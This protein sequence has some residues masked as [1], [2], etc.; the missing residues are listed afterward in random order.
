MRRSI[1]LFYQDVVSPFVREFEETRSVLKRAF[2]AV[3][4]L[5]SFASHIFYFHK[6]LQ[7]LQYTGD[8][9]F[10][11]N[12]LIPRSSDFK[13]ILDVSAAA[14][15]ALR[16]NLDKSKTSV[17][18]STDLISMNVEGWAAFFGGLNADEWGDQVIVHNDQHLFA[19]LLPV[20]LRAETF[21]LGIE[22]G[23]AGS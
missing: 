6:D 2:G 14:K 13:L 4:A 12:V 18:S 23:Y 10:K 22:L 17:Y 20:V 3:W 11:K 15:H 9:D 21:L 16:S 5:D 7:K 19:P 8:I 1:D